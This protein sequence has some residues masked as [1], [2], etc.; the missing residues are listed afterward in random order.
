MCPN[1]PYL[2]YNASLH[3]VVLVCMSEEIKAVAL[4]EMYTK[5]KTDSY[6][7]IRVQINIWSFKSHTVEAFSPWNKIS[8]SENLKM[9]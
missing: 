6:G 3:K 8:P 2:L 9:H 7:H 4:L 1:C 5:V